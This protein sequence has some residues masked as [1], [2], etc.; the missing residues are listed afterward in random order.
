M[1]VWYHRS[2]FILCDDITTFFPLSSLCILA[3]L[4]ACK[5][6][7]KASSYLHGYLAISRELLLKSL[8]QGTE[9]WQ[10]CLWL[11]LF[12]NSQAMACEFLLY[13]SLDCLM[14]MVLVIL[15]TK[16]PWANFRFPNWRWV[17]ADARL[18]SVVLAL[19]KAVLGRW[20]GGVR[21]S[22]PEAPGLAGGSLS[23]L[24]HCSCL[25]FFSCRSCGYRG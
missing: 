14:N 23:W 2:N 17:Q 9:C 21:W 6:A 22:L 12:K 11:T 10:W 20:D 13:R 3:R 25:L 16:S 18:R 7:G 8:S 1:E 24:S 5:I 15:I 4:L 19:Q